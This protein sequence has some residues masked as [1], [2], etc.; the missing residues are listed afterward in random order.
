MTRS[1]TPT[2]RPGGAA[3]G[4]DGG[5][6]A[7]GTAAAVRRRRRLRTVDLRS[8]EKKKE[9][10]NRHASSFRLRMRPQKRCV[11]VRP[12][13]ILTSLAARLARSVHGHFDGLRVGGHL[14]W[15]GAHRDRQ[16]EA[17]AWS[18]RGRRGQEKHKAIGY[19][20]LADSS[21]LLRHWWLT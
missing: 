3:G 14:R 6:T 16:R 11:P 21:L 17:L 2:G 10:K 18:R 7:P 4:G 5:R 15:G 20:R 9:R 13:A 19:N 12:R 1:L 8:G